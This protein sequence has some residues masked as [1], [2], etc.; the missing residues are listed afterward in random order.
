MIATIIIVMKRREEIKPK[1][2]SD[3]QCHC[4]PGDQCPA[5][6]QAVISPFQVTF[7]VFI[8]NMTSY[9][10]EYPFGQFGSA[11]LAVLPPSLLCSSSFT[12]HEALESP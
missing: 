6:P 4:L 1:K 7:T 9:G 11:L 12:E 8:L 5:P 2:T 10:A 3:V